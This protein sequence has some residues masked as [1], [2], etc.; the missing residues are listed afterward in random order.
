ML[1]FNASRYRN[2]LANFA[3]FAFFVYTHRISNRLYASGT[4]SGKQP[5]CHPTHSPFI[6][7]I[8]YSLHVL[9]VR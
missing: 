7:S 4:R 8:R 3:V 2:R 1:L 5:Y 6:G 9:F